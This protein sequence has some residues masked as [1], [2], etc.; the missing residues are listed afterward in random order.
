MSDAEN[1]LGVES[2]QKIP[3]S[4]V[5]REGED[6]PELTDGELYK[7]V[8]MPDG[9]VVF[10]LEE[11]VSHWQLIDPKDREKAQGTFVRN[12]GLAA[13]RGGYVYLTGSSGGLTA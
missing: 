9:K 7:Y 3:E 6:L 11:A 8:E 1:S 10:G 12:A 13:V 4:V 2:G 5:V